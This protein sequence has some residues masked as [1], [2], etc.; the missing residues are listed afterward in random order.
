MS[1]KTVTRQDRIQFLTDNPD[2]WEGYP[3]VFSMSFAK[4][5]DRRIFEAMQKAR[6]FSKQTLLADVNL[7]K[8]IS[9][10]RFVRRMSQ[11]QPMPELN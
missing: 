2:L 5:H 8:L 7:E 4:S 9:Q 6:L 1:A 10:A 11:Q 3:K